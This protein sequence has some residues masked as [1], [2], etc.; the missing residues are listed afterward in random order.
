MLTSIGRKPASPELLDLLLECHGRIRAFTTLAVRLS[1]ARD[2]PAAE[3]AD[4]AERVAQYFGRALPLHAQDEEL[5]LVPRLRGHDEQ[6]D[7]ELAEMCEEHEAHE[8]SVAELVALCSALR[9][10]PDR[11]LELAPTLGE[12]ARELQAHFGPH[13]AREEQHIFPALATQLDANTRA[14]IVK[15]MRA[16]R[17]A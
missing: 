11:H 14:E 8:E 10:E 13:L 5:S 2:V 9:D 4:S 17:S 12:T 6:L 3:I 15:E 1:E 7:D 16:R